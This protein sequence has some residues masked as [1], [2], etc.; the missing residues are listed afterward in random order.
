[1]DLHRWSVQQLQSGQ[2]ECRVISDGPETDMNKLRWIK[3]GALALAQKKVSIVTPYFL[4]DRG[5]TDALGL[6]AMRGVNVEIILPENNNLKLVHWATY[7]MLWQVIIPGCKVFMQRGPFDHSK[8][9]V[10]DDYWSFIGSSNWDARS[11]RLNFEMNLE[12]YDRDLAQRLAVIIDEKKS[13]SYQLTLAEV[14]GR[15]MWQ[16]IRDGF[17]RLFTPYL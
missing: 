12:C 11:L 4:P 6:A 16:K 7:S 1:V 13:R 15:P 14:D 5:L 3:M 8:L 2:V 10:V 9:M 17:C